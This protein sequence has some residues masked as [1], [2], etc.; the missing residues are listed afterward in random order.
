MHAHDKETILLVCGDDI[1]AAAILTDLYHANI[2]VVGPISTAK[3]ALALVAQTGPTL[4]LLA[5]QPTGE[6]KA[7]ELAS[8]LMSTW[9]VRTMLL[10]PTD[11]DAFAASDWR[12]SD[13]QVASIRRA[14]SQSRPSA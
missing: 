12:A 13:H 5:G 11:H 14:L 3:M 4:A 2:R 7:S 9:G 10:D 8:A 6:R 1:D